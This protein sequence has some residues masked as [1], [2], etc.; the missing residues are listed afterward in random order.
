V[1]S[2]ETLAN[3]N[4]EVQAH[5]FWY[6][7]MDLAP[8]VTTPGWF[9]LRPVVDKMPW[10]DVRGK[11]CLDIGTFDGFLA[12]E[13]ERRGAAEVHAI[14]I[15]DH[16]RWDWPA[17][18]RPEVV[19]T[20]NRAPAF[21]GPKKGDGFRLAARILDSKVQWHPLSMYD[22]NP[23]LL[24]MFDVITCGTLLLHL[25]DPVRALEAVRSVCRGHLLSS[26]QIEL[27]LSVVHRGKPVFRLRGSGEECQWWL[28]NASGHM[29]LLI[30]AGFEIEGKSRPYV[31]EYNVHPKPAPT[32]FYLARGAM[33]R[34]MT[35]ARRP[36]VFHR[37]LLARPNL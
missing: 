37:A 33:L 5:P 4:R 23:D 7:T 13:L 10:P 32:P 34:V 3:W 2:Q 8:G 21:R 28:A 30:S 6:H 29:R 25:R 24:G 12:F 31:V 36:G 11:R 35:G 14:D 9:D 27:G 15:E 1:Q 18:A 22:L 20:D 17:D 16:E 19:G 26:E